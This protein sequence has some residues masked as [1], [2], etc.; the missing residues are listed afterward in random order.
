LA[1]GAKYVDGKQAR[2]IVEAWLDTPFS[3]EERHARRIK[4]IEDYERDNLC[5][6]D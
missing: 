1:L 4:K 6:P 2:Q 5:N 3:G